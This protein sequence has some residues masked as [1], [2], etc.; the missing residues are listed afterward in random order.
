MAE[1]LVAFSCFMMIM[2]FFLPFC[3]RMVVTLQ[4]KQQRVEALK[5][6]HEGMERAIVTNDFNPQTRTFEGIVYTFSWEEARSENAC[7]SYTKGGE[8]HEVCASE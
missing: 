8:S 2:A 7:V 5:F 6:L 3:I 1:S 4:D